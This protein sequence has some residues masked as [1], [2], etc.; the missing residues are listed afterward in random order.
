MARYSLTA[1]LF[2]LDEKGEALDLA[3]TLEAIAAAGFGEVELMAEGAEWEK[4]G[5]H[6]ARPCRE[7]L[8]RTGIFPHTIHTPMT[9]VDLASSVEAIR[10]DSVARIGDAMRF[11]G[12][13]GGRTAIVHPTGHPTPDE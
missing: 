8:E 5:A 9:G 11:L 13:V 2:S 3:A 10:R 12:E 4:P 1:G 7:A 6:D